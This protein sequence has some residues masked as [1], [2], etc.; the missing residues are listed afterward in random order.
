MKR[1]GLFLL[2]AFF[3]VSCGS[4]TITNQQKS[5]KDK[6][7]D[8]N[9]VLTY[10]FNITDTAAR[11]DIS[12]TIKYFDLFPFDKVQLTFVLDDPSSEKRTSEHDL[13]IRNN[14]GRFLGTK[15]GDTII[16]NF[17]IR[18]HYQFKATGLTKIKLINRLPYPVT[19][20]LGGISLIIKKR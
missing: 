14:E 6:R 3:L 8:R 20:G 19:D 2:L 17:E 9:Q 12:T 16:K 18:N 1:I 11:Y 5:F 4:K 10:A 15:S 13:L 7:W